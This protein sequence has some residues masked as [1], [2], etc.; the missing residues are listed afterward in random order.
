MSDIEKY[1]KECQEEPTGL[2]LAEVKATCKEDVESIIR[3]SLP[4]N[5]WS[6]NKEFSKLGGI[7][8]DQLG[9]KK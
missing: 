7:L 4:F 2:T 5:I 9:V 6:I 3:T 8:L 1:W